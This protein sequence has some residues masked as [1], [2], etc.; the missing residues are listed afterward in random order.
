MEIKWVYVHN[1]EY[2]KPS[3]TVGQY[4]PAGVW[5]AES[6]WKSAEEATAR[7]NYLTEGGEMFTDEQ[8]QAVNGVLEKKRADPTYRPSPEELNIMS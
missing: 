1:S 8:R 5:N 6:D 2:G 3:F 7:I 4:E